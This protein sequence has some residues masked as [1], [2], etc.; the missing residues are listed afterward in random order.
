VK[1]ELHD[2]KRELK[3]HMQDEKSDLANILKWKWAVL[4]VFIFLV[5]RVDLHG[6]Y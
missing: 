2:I 6:K 1:E 3:E 5:L 4:A